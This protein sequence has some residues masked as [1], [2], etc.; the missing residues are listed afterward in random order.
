MK[1]IYCVHIKCACAS[2][3]YIAKK[4]TR[5]E[6]AWPPILNTNLTYGWEDLISDFALIIAGTVNGIE[7][8][9]EDGVLLKDVP[10]KEI[11][12]KNGVI[13]LLTQEG[14]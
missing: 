5:T 10:R 4:N 3:S 11:R 12:L 9:I 1:L 2:D 13:K 8:R 7:N 14:Y 6:T